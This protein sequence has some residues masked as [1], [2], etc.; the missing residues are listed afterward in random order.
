MSELGMVKADLKKRQKYLDKLKE[1]LLSPIKGTASRALLKEPEPYIS[2]IGDLFIY[3]TDRGHCINPYMS[4][5]MVRENWNHN[6]WSA[7]T[8]IDRGRA[9]DYLTWYRAITVLDALEGRPS[10]E[11]LQSVRWILRNPGT[12]SID[13]L[14]KMELTKIE[15]V[16]ISPKKINRFFPSS[17]TGF[18]EA[19]SG[20]SIANH[21]S[22]QPGWQLLGGV[23]STPP[24]L[25]EL[26][27]IIS[28]LVE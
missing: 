27:Q 8:I 3:P 26:K 13:Q 24:K 1:R 16:Q 4:L 28:R 6:S 25:I 12:L 23:S 11:K 20:I 15:T 22:V 10:F 2:D 5:Q 14:K 17:P 7:A 19:I 9:L 18:I 21:L